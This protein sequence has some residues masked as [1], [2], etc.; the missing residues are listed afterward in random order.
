MKAVT[1]NHQSD[2]VSEQTMPRLVSN[3]TL[4]QPEAVAKFAKL[5]NTQLFA[6]GFNKPNVPDDKVT[7]IGVF[8]GTEPVIVQVVQRDC[9][10][11][12]DIVAHYFN[13]SSGTFNLPLPAEVTY[14]TICARILSLE[15]TKQVMQARLK[16]MFFGN[17]TTSDNV[18]AFVLHSATYTQKKKFQCKLEY[19]VK[20]PEQDV[21][22]TYDYT[23]KPNDEFT[24]L[25]TTLALD[26]NTKFTVSGRIVT[27]TKKSTEWK[28]NA[29]K[30]DLLADDFESAC[31]VMNSVK[32]LVVY[33]NQHLPYTSTILKMM[34]ESVCNKQSLANFLSAYAHEK[35]NSTKTSM[36][37]AVK[38]SDYVGL[39]LW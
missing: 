6:I 31:D 1:I 4:N 3:M 2:T 29:L 28:V 17:I 9:G 15:P 22:K 39:D 32:N 16:Q 18:Q 10:Q 20:L 26:T 14:Q 21:T 8:S 23:G 37:Y 24:K 5:V 27:A 25:V 38:K 30:F 34:S 33:T 36:T 11:K 7:V 13:H 19:S 35:K 12:Y